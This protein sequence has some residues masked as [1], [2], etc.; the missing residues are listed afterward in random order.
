V[1]V[2]PGKEVDLLHRRR[3]L[4]GWVDRREGVFPKLENARI[5]DDGRI[6]WVEICFCDHTDKLERKLAG[7]GQAFLDVPRGR[8]RGG[9][10]SF[11]ASNNLNCA[12]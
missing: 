2:K 4:G 5:Y 7:Q 3:Q 12:I 8:I 10:G 11:T 1:R 9:L 6:K